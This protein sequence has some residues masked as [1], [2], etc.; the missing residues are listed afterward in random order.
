MGVVNAMVIV[1]AEIGMMQLIRDL[2]I[3]GHLLSALIEDFI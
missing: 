1:H 3:D 2:S